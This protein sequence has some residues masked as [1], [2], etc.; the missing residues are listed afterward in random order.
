MGYN[1]ANL[2]DKHERFHIEVFSTLQRLPG[3]ELP[4]QD[5]FQKPDFLFQCGESIVGIEHTE[6]KELG[7][8]EGMQS[9][10][11]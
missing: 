10:H 4:R 11:N 5:I 3:V 6:I 7:S 2:K 1:Q 9:Q 8:S